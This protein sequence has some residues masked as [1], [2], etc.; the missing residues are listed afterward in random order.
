M[1]E[2]K[3]RKGGWYWQ[4]ITDEGR[5]VYVSQQQYI[6]D[7]EANAAA[8]RVRQQFCANSRLLDTD[9]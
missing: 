4:F 1:I 7:H 2:V 9:Y 8:K 6:S 5:V 3:Y